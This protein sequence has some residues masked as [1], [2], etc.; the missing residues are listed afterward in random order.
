MK[1]SSIGHPQ[2]VTGEQEIA[3]LAIRVAEL[4]GACLAEAELVRDGNANAGAW[5]RLC[6]KRSSAR[7]KLNELRAM[8]SASERMKRNPDYLAS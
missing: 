6:E 2:S 7:K 5:A 1:T 4:D 8:H 3:R